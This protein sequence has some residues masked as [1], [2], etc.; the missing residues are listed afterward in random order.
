MFCKN[1]PANPGGFFL[2]WDMGGK[3][4]L[5][6]FS[7]PLGSGM[8]PEGVIVSLNSQNPG[9]QETDGSIVIFFEA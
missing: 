6:P 5:S 7:K 8:R 2:G 3:A 9:C 4:W 1:R